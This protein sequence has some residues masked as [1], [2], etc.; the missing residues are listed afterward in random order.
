MGK[1]KKNIYDNFLNIVVYILVIFGYIM[2]ISAHSAVFVKFGAQTFAFEIGKITVYILIGILCMFWV[3]GNFSIKLFFNHKMA[4]TLAIGL[5][6]VATLLYPEVNG[7]KRWIRLPLITIQ[8]IEFFKL[9]FI[10][11]LSYHFYYWKDKK[12]TAIRVLAGPIAA[13]FVIA[14]FVFYLQ[15]DLGSTLILYMIGLIIF[16]AVPGKRYHNAKLITGVIIIIMLVLFYTLGPK[17]SDYIYNL[18]PTSS[19]KIRLLRIAVLFD[20]LKDVLEY[21]FQLTQSLTAMTSAGFIGLNL[22]NSEVKHILPEPYNDAIIAVIA[23]ETGLIGLALLFILFFLIIKRIFSY[24]IIARKNL[25]H[26]L[27]L[28]GLASYF[29][30]QFFV[31][32]GGMIGLIPMTGVTLPFVSSGGSSTIT[33]FIAIGIAQ[34]IIK[35]YRNVKSRT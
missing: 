3:R 5:M 9:Y 18:P 22:G 15:G 28:I 11:M 17:F 16:F 34:S 33:S 24:S 12:A 32:V 4:I 21:G 2:V 19:L 29:M 20:P 10:I 7:S 27:V 35:R 30:V 8:P 13:M 25:L 6:M 31:N 14:V 26:S 23:E 1:A